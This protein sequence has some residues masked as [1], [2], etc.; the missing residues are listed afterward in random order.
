MTTIVFRLIA[1]ILVS[2]TLGVQAQQPRIG[3]PLLPL[4]DGPFVFDT[5]EQH[6]IRVTVMAKGLSHP[7]AIAFLP[8]GAMLIPERSGQLRI[9]RNGVLDPKPI[10]GVPR[11]RTDGN[12]GL[13][14]VAIHPRFTENRLVYLTYTKPVE[15][16]KGTPS[17][18]RGRLDGHRLVDVQD[19]VVPDAYE[20]NGGL[21]GRVAFGTVTCSL[22]QCANNP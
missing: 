7:W 2:T 10:D 12:C 11:V 20:G 3:V 18:A 21:N 15:N 19:L 9:V 5:A 16:G 6:K 4:G 8:D 14:D 13:M 1:V 22:T 17:L